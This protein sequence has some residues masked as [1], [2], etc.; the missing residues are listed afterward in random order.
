MDALDVNVHERAAGKGEVK[1]LNREGFIPGVLYSHGESVPVAME[2]D[3]VR[4]ILDK[5]GDVGTELDTYYRGT[6]IK[7]RVMEVQRDPV[8][9]EIKHIDLMPADGGVLH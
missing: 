9:Q 1:R 5:K 8:S 3:P 2:R 4:K 6:Q 7:V